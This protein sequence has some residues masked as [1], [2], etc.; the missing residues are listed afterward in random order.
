MPFDPSLPAPNSPLESQVIR[1]QLQALFNLI[2][3][4]TTLTAAQVDGVN[5]VPPGSPAQVNVSVSGNT[6]RFSFDIPRGQDGPA[7]SDGNEGPPGSDG[8]PGPPFAHAI[9]AGVTTLEPWAEATVDATFDG[10][11]VHLTFG[12]PRGYDGSHGNDG[13]PGP[14]GDVNQQ[15]LEDA[16]N[17]TSP[18]TNAVSTLDTPFAEPDMEAMRLKLN[19]LI[20]NGRRW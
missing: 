2:H 12:I 6:L 13:S 17:G 8:P 3:D 5:T 9:V 20:L 16:I 4:I 7:G 14:P 10:T 11:N 18:N 15:Q 19:E 1:D